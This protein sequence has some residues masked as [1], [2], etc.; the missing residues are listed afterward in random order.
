MGAGGRIMNTKDQLEPTVFIIFGGA[1]DLTWRKLVPALFD[2]SQ[3]RRVPAHFAIIVV[4]RA[5]MSD[6]SL[7][8]RLHDGVKRFAR[9]GKSAAGAWAGFARHF[10]YQQGDFKRLQT[11]AALG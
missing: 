1:G 5:E 6:A 11:Y 2:L 7:R 4:D 9:H 8:R 3:D 10:H